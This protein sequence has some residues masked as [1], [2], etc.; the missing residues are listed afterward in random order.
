MGIRDRASTIVVRQKAAATVLW[1]S[2]A[3]QFAPG[4]DF[5][6]TIEVFE[7]NHTDES[8]LTDKPVYKT[9]LLYTS[10]CV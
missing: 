9:C 10:R 1:S 4:A 3:S 6:Y 5:Q 2:N 8:K 7:G